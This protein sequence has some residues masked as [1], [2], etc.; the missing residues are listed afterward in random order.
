MWCR[1]REIERRI[2]H[3]QV[4]LDYWE[5]VVKHPWSGLIADTAAEEIRLK[6]NVIR[7]LKKI[8]NGCNRE[9]V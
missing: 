8:K 2:K 6:S 4:G 5:M 1:T 9:R 3:H 7:R